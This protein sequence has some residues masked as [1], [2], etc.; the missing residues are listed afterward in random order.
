MLLK[1]LKAFL[2][3]LSPRGNKSGTDVDSSPSPVSLS[4]SLLISLH[5]S[6]SLSLSCPHTLTV[7]RFELFI[8]DAWLQLT[9][10]KAMWAQDNS[11]YAFTHPEAMSRI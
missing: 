2:S 9:F 5:F 1:S 4:R 3:H 10:P 7:G 8:Y 6:I 11:I